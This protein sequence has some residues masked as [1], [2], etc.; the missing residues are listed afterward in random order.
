MGSRETQVL[1]S[2]WILSAQQSK[3]GPALAFWAPKFF[4]SK[5]PSPK[6]LS[7]SMSISA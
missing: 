5:A 4:M 6:G 2:E 1:S 3:G 7:V